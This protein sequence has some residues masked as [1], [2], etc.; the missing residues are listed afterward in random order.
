MNEC[1]FSI[2]SA[3]SVLSGSA[4]AKRT[5]RSADRHYLYRREGHGPRRILDQEA[6]VGQ[7]QRKEESGGMSVDVDV[8]VA[9]E[10]VG[11]RCCCC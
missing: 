8:D 9:G 11:G 2:W 1:E 4:V 10:D 3:F 5:A 6:V 7:S